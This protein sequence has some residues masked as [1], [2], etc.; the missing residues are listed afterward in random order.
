MTTHTDRAY[1]RD[2]NNLRERLLV[3]GKRVQAMIA[4]S[5][6]ALTARDS[7]LA[8]HVLKSDLAVNRLE[9]E[10]DDLCRKIIAL[11][12]PAASDLR[13]ITTAVKIVT[14]LE[15]VGDLAVNIAER[16][17]D[18]NKAEPLPS[19]DD[20][21]R[22]AELAQSQLRNA[23]ESFVKRDVVQAERVLTSDDFLD[24][25]FV[26]LFNELLQLMMEE[27]KTIRRA[28]SLLFVAKHLERIG[29]HATNV[30]EMVI[31]LVKGTDVRHPTSRTGG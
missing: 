27:S 6:L 9:L 1:E 10:I 4:E 14:D 17:T 19:Y 13:L 21:P 23:L 26:K 31:Y 7:K 3:M 2:L 30:A 25:L 20:L 15:R 8:E 11:R 18:L 22:L 16:A 28:T 12:Q 5:V 24:A 29:D